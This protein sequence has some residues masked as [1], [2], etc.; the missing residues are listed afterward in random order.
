MCSRIVMRM[1][2]KRIHV[3]TFLTSLSSGVARRELF[4]AL[5]IPDLV[6]L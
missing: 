6:P 4:D 5:D 3:I 2:M 1:I